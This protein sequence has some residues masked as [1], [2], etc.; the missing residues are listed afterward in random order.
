MSFTMYQYLRRMN[1]GF[2]NE[3][4]CGVFFCFFLS[5]VN[6]SLLKLDTTAKKAKVKCAQDISLLTASNFSYQEQFSVLATPCRPGSSSP[7][8]A[9]PDHFQVTTHKSAF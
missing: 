2:Q 6:F 8:H 1:K 7:G 5:F 4:I 3:L 9:F